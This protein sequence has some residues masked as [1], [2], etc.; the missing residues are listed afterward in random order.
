[1]TII[2]QLSF[3]TDKE[4][5]LRRECPFCQKEFKVKFNQEEISDISNQSIE[6]FLVEESSEQ[7]DEYEDNTESFYFCPY[8]GQYSSFNNWWT[9][10]QVKYIHIVCKNIMAQLINEH[11]VKP[12][13]KTSRSSSFLKIEAKPISQQQEWIGT[14]ADD[15]KEVTLKC[16]ER[17]IKL[18]DNWDKKV[19]CH[20][21]GF[22]HKNI[23]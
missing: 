7:N 19:F 15:L 21:C 20:F 17:Q 9:K 2:K 1:M 4:G 22:P 13:Q 5:F 10:E 3:P 8:C 16:C 12:L 18:I 6:Q 14:E 23:V 11:L